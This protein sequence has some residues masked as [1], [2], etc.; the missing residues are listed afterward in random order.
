MLFSLSRSWLSAFHPWMAWTKSKHVT[1]AITTFKSWLFI[2]NSWQQNKWIQMVLWWERALNWWWSTNLYPPIQSTPL[3]SSLRLL[4]RLTCGSVSE[5]SWTFDQFRWPFLLFFLSGWRTSCSF[6]K[7]SRRNQYRMCISTFEHGLSQ[8]FGMQDS[9]HEHHNIMGMWVEGKQHDMKEE[10]PI[11]SSFNITFPNIS[12]IEK[13]KT[14]SQRKL[15]LLI[16]K[17]LNRSF[18]TTCHVVVL[19]ISNSTISRYQ[20]NKKKDRCWP[21]ITT[22]S[23]RCQQILKLPSAN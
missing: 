1:T 18:Q 21:A 2:D 13:S 7:K 3:W 4:L 17:V 5:N 9:N 19:S 14:S 20:Q 11:I 16:L 23:L 15:L 22:E 6:V 10:H 12:R 8:W